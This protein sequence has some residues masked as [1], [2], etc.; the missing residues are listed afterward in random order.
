MLLA[1]ETGTAACSV[2]LIDG[3]TIVAARHE[4]IGRG[5]AERLVPLVEDVLAEAGIQPRSVAVDVGPGSFT[6]LRV[7]IA[8]ARGFGLVWNIPVSGFSSTSLVAAR[9][10]AASNADRL[11]VVIDAGRGE[12]FAQTF[13]RDL[14]PDAP[15]AALPVTTAAAACAG[16]LAGTGASLLQK[17][18]S[19]AVILF[20]SPPDARDAALLS[21]DLRNLAP[22]PLYVRAPDAKLPA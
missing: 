19:T 14:Q 16:P 20:D 7:G 17:A 5:H 3:T 15:P 4:I 6:G 22:T 18:G 9:A 21:A 13:G 10:F 12:V 1:I 2:A 8:A 11:T